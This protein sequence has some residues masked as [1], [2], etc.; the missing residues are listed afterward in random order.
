MAK[1]LRQTGQTERQLTHKRL[2]ADIGEPDCAFKIIE[3][4]G[5]L[6]PWIKSAVIMVCCAP[7]VPHPSC[8]HTPPCTVS[9]RPCPAPASPIAHPAHCTPAPPRHTPHPTPHTVPLHPPPLIMLGKFYKKCLEW[10]F[11]C[12]HEVLSAIRIICCAHPL[13]PPHAPFWSGP[14]LGR[15]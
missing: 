10:R 14:A 6:F 5:A 15:R 4:L 12:S 7:L 13:P 11:T 9:L 3:R 1:R 8:C 2:T